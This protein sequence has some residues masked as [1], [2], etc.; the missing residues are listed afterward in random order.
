MPNIT[1]SSGACAAPSIRQLCTFCV[2]HLLLGVDLDDVQE[3]LRFQDITPVPLAHPVVR[4]LINLRGQ[5]VTALDLRVRMGMGSRAADTAPMNVVVRHR[6]GIASLLVDEIGDVVEVDPGRYE[7]PPQTLAP[8]SRQLIDGVY[9]L[10]PRLLLLLNTQR[11]VRV[12][13]PA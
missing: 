5:I 4:G 3:V 11:A 1:D 13:A 10:E 12:D 2:D 7:A 8:A 6:D 9:K